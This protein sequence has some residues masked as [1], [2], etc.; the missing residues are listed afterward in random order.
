[1]RQEPNGFRYVIGCDPGVNGAIVVLKNGRPVKKFETPKIGSEFDYAYLRKFLLHYKNKGAVIYFEELMGRG[2]GWG[3]SQNFKMARAYEFIKSTS[4]ALRFPNYEIKPR[5]W[6]E[7][8]FKNTKIIWKQGKKKKTKD[9]K[10]MA[11]VAARRMFPEFDLR[12]NSRCS[13]V[14]DGIVDALLIAYYGDL[15]QR[16]KNG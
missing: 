12:K 5:T 6:Q 15:E 4:M 11:L 2:G 9:T 3:A 10:A 16:G 1:M 7:V 14:H 13:K 8:M